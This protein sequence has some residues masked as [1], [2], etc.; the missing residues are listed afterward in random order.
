MKLKTSPNSDQDQQRQQ[1]IAMLKEREALL[2][3]LIDD[4]EARLDEL[5]S[6]ELDQLSAE[7]CAE[8]E[9]II[10]TQEEA[11]K[12]LNA[13]QEEAY[14]QLQAEQKAETK[15]LETKKAE[16]DQ[17]LA[18]KEMTKRVQLAKILA[19]CEKTRKNLIKENTQIQMMQHG[20]KNSLD[21]LSHKEDIE[22]NREL[23]YLGILAFSVF[24][25]LVGILYC[26]SLLYVYTKQKKELQKS[27]TVF[28]NDLEETST[29]V[30]TR[31]Q[32]I[33][34]Q[35]Y[36]DDLDYREL[37]NIITSLLTER[38]ELVKA[39]LDLISSA[40]EVHQ[41]IFICRLGLATLL[42]I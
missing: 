11:I 7:E 41:R 26:I 20:V 3:Q 4:L 28:H 33:F 23:L 42:R 1:K 16:L 21:K 17:I 12:Q 24:E 13:L 25:P 22:R 19:E 40:Q 34:E 38:I 35:T 18:E 5:T 32:K 36:L 31:K 27:K 15:K 9:R 30:S 14:D 8:L 6:G 37:Y 29:M 39:L 10:S 2:I